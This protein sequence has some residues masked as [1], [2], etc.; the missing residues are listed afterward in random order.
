MT[1]LA[2]LLQTVGISL[3]GVMAPGPITAVTIG[4]G[5]A[6]PH[7]GAK[8]AIGH[9][10]VEF[11][12]MIALYFGFGRLISY[13]PVKAGIGVIGGVFLCWMGVGMLKSIR[14]AVTAS[15]D[16]RSATSAGILLTLGNPYFLIWW[17]SVGAFLILR[18]VEFGIWGFVLFAFVH[19]MCDFVWLY[20]LSA[21]IHKGR[22]F[23]G[24]VFQEWLFGICGVF[25]VLF[26]VKFMIDALRI[27]IQNS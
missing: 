23:F 9:G 5:S 7:A 20:F 2:F 17:V 15:H 27:I 11:P 13:W 25:L 19:W 26:S 24:R 18:A 1:Y 8:I 3:S 14:Q 4:K 10:M 22:S 16:A 21:L 6:S 12:L